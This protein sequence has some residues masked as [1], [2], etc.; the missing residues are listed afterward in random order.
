M[1]M[2]NKLNEKNIGA[3]IELDAA[4][5]FN[6]QVFGRRFK[7]KT[8]FSAIAKWWITL[9]EDEQKR[10]YSRANDENFGTFSEWVERLIDEKLNIK[11]KKTPEIN[12]QETVENIIYFTKF[13]LPSSKERQLLNN[14][15]ETL[16]SELPK[17]AKRKRA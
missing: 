9:S 14:L 16:K 10:F 4:E 15:F 1:V 3:A 8:L 11:A 17:Q 6:K 5:E 12:L 2:P 13:K 7:M